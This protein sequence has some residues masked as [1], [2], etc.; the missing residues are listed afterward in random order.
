[1]GSKP[2][3]PGAATP[4][5]A[6]ESAR[7][8]NRNLLIAGVLLVAALA[9]WWLMRS[10]GDSAVERETRAALEATEGATRPSSMDAAESPVAQAPPAADTLD[11]EPQFQRY[12][13][14]KY[15]LLFRDVEGDASVALRA[16]LLE[17]ERV[18]VLIN[19]AKQSSDPAGRES[20]P[21]LEARKAEADRAVGTLLPAS[22][23]GAF[24][25]LKDS[26]IERFQ[27]E[28]YAAGIENVAPLAPADKQAVLATKLEYRQRFRRVLADSRLMTG[29]LNGTERL[30]AFNEVSRALKEYQQSY[31]QEV[32][33][34]LYNDEQF[35]LLSN[36][37]TTE[38]N[39][40]LAKLRSIA[41]L[42]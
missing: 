35:T 40:E 23:L 39:A 34:Y 16:A 8:V 31:L 5:A 41:G 20:L 27:V 6:D 11:S 12:V 37:E 38:Y 1:M 15:R 2:F 21:A 19:T 42:D 24:E 30:L 3:R 22:E 29:D 36:Y 17:R 13:D 7:Q 14:D 32:R 28:D 26:D 10:P 25:A 4:P 18:V 9:T 33:Q